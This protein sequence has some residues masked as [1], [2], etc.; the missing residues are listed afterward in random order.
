MPI[1]GNMLKATAQTFV[2]KLKVNDK[3]KTYTNVS[4]TKKLPQIVIGN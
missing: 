3:L 1:D 2:A 4:G